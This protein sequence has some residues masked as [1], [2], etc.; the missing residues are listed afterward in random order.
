M[1]K[2]I[3]DTEALIERYHNEIDN[4][5]RML[6]EREMEAPAKSQRLSACEVSLASVLYSISLHPGD[7][8]LIA[9][10]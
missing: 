8:R 10:G 3:V 4:L 6:E 1:K 7:A 2:E 9:N 5:K